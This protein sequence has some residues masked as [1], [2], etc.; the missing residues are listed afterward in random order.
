MFDRVC[1][2]RTTRSRRPKANP[3][4]TPTIRTVSVHWTFGVKSPRHRRTMATMT[5]GVA[6]AVAISRIRRSWLSRRW[7]GGLDVAA[8]TSLVVLDAADAQS[9]ALEPPV[10]G[11]AAQAQRVGCPAYVAVEARQGFL[12]EEA[13]HVLQAHIL[14]ARRRFARR[15]QAQIGRCDLSSLRHKH[16]ALHHVVELAHVA[17]PGVREQRL[18]RRGIEA[19]HQFLIAL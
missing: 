14:E 10:K 7:V 15:P 1:S 3:I 19:G 5:A 6:A 9:V 8:L 2:G 17:R 12:N 11:A 16:G 13:L 18:H 4:Q